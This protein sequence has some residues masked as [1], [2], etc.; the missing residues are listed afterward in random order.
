MQDFWEETS[1][2]TGNNLTAIGT[3]LSNR[4][5]TLADAFH[6]YAIAVKFNKA[7]GGG[8]AYPYCFEEGP[9]YVAAAGSTAVQKTISTVGGSTSAASVE[10]N[11]A[12]NWVAL[13]AS[14]GPYDVTLSNTSAGGQLRGTVAC[15][16]G[17][18]LS[19]APLPVVV[20]AGATT[21]LAGF[22]P[23]SCVG[24]PV[25]AVTNQSQ[26]AANPTSSTARSYQVSTAASGGGGTQPLSVAKAGSGSG[27]V[28]S[29]PSGIN[30]GSDC[31]ESYATG[32]TVTL[33]ATPAAGSTFSGWS[34]ACAG[35][36]ATCQVTMTAAKSVTA[37]FTA[38]QQ[39]SVAKSGSGT[40]TSSPS[41]IDCGSDCTQ[42]YAPGTTV[43]LSATPASGWRFS[44]WSGD[45]SGLGCTV[46]MSAAR[47]VTA[48]FT[49]VSTGSTPPPTSP[50]TSPV[51]PVVVDRTAP[52]Q[53]LLSLSSS[54]FRAARSGPSAR[55]SVGLGTRVRYDLSEPATTR[56]RVERAVRGRRVGGRCVRA[57]RANATRR[58]CT[59]WALLRGS[60]TRSGQR[61]ANRFRFTGRLSGRALRRGRYRLVARSTDAAGNRST[62]R[63]V[64]FRIVG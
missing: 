63:R 60:F 11:Y 10:D 35:A 44:G 24:T 41:G 18:T 3:A 31:S 20:G 39:L 64:R 57:T 2:N 17:T 22:N 49:P 55:T 37:T 58:P 47:S 33:T 34:G 23:S 53:A 28:T 8:Y 27:T 7:C 61:G 19:L 38:Q 5:T 50:L 4:G 15:D 36:G 32:T 29:S 13:P 62:L 59:R 43:T 30:C 51:A 48:V 6:A 42:L 26:T 52:V 16:T 40:V 14:G 12:L 25:L 56:F 54:S 1:K 45:C 9:A 46:T 21:T